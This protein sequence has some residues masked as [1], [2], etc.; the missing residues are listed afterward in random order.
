MKKTMLLLALFVTGL[1]YSQIQDAWVFFADK[2][3]VANSIANPLTILTQESIDRKAL[4]NVPIDERDVPV[5]ENYITQ[6]KNAQGVSVF[7][8]SKWMNCVYVQGTQSDIEDLLNNLSFSAVMT[9]CYIIGFQLLTSD[10]VLP[11]FNYFVNL[12]IKKRL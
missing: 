4:H 5:D 10:F 11:A 9:G 2:E 7:A 6:I 8:K 12:R 3:D 1:G